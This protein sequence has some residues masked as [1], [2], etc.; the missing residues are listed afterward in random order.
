MKLHSPKK[1]NMTQNHQQSLH[2]GG[3]S[4]ETPH[5][6]T[7]KK[8]NQWKGPMKIFKTYIYKNNTYHNNTQC[9]DYKCIYYL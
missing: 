9:T 2:K 8:G 4:K 1:S 5:L 3:A 6:E 7:I